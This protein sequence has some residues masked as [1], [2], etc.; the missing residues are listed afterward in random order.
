[1]NAT[2]SEIPVADDEA[3][4][5]LIGCSGDSAA[6]RGVLLEYPLALKPLGEPLRQAWGQ[7][8]GKRARDEI[9]QPGLGDSCVP[10]RIGDAPLK[11]ATL[12]SQRSPSRVEAGARVRRL[13]LGSRETLRDFISFGLA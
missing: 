5:E 2:G 8:N 11:L 9:A 12:L 1:M 7:R 13:A 4:G 10:G 6:Y 3:L